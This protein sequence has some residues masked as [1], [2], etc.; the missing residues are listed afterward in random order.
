MAST[1][2]VAS[3]PVGHQHSLR[4]PRAM[5]GGLL[6]LA[7]PVAIWFVPLHID[8]TPKHALAV[9]SFMI[10]AW[11]S[12]VMPHAVTGLIGCYLFWVLGRG[13]IRRGLRG[14]SRSD[15]VVSLWRR[16]D[17]NDG[18][19]IGAGA[20][21]SVSGDAAARGRAIREFCWG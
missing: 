8:A 11:I 15:A 16:A 12:E 20:A 18:D 17:R 4:T 10:I 9:A 5:I 2:E 19:E 21:A 7:V 14:A 1:A 3:A 13:E 6:S